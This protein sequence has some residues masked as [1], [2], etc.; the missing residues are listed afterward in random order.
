MIG[1]IAQ[2]CAQTKGPT[3]KMHKTNFE[4]HGLRT[5]LHLLM[6]YGSARNVAAKFVKFFRIFKKKKNYVL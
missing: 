4:V 2:N 1:A 6:C 3:I 5:N